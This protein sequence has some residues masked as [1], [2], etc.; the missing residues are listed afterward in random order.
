MSFAK[1]PYGSILV[2]LE[3]RKSWLSLTSSMLYYSPPVDFSTTSLQSVNPKSNFWERNMIVVYFISSSPNN[4]ESHLN[5]LLV[6]EWLRYNKGACPIRFTSGKI[7]VV[8][9]KG[10]KAAQRPDHI[11]QFRV[12]IFNHLAKLPGCNVL[13]LTH[14]LQVCSRFYSI[15]YP[16][17]SNPAPHW[18]WSYPYHGCWP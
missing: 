3:E 14:R 18:A 11:S 5:R 4:I 12:I 6:T 13:S 7:R 17:K 16:Y 9:C 8:Y 2:S 10:A 15:F 1:S